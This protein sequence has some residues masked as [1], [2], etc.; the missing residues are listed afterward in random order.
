M[1]I[2]ITGASSG[3]GAALAYHASSLGH[4]VINFSRNKGRTGLVHFPLD[5]EHYGTARLAATKAVSDF[6]VPSMV[7]CCAARGDV[8]GGACAFT[9]PDEILLPILHSN[10]TGNLLF[11]AAC[12]AAMASRPDP[13]SLITLVSSL[14][15]HVPFTDLPAYC[16]S[17]AALEMGAKLLREQFSVSGPRVIIARPGQMTT[18]FFEKANL[19][20][21][22]PESARL[23]IAVASALFESVQREVTDVTI[24]LDDANRI[25]ASFDTMVLEI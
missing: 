15:A 14:G 23:P 19:P 7:F 11:A 5:L 9:S 8:A 18:P 17:K 22:A 20:A 6:G 25:D 12:A 2:F 13:P 10:F 21:P 24:G 3:L 4:D 1:L 16:I